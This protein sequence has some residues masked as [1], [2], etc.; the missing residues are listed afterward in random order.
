VGQPALDANFSRSQLPSVDSFLGELF[1]AE[2]VRVS[3][4]RAAAKSAKFAANETHIGEIDI[5]VDDVS[6]K[7]SDQV[8]TQCVGGDEKA[9]KVVA[10][11]IG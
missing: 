9:E 6:D 4:A 3:F 5:T 10:F 1:E 7:I 8:P 11:G 2:E